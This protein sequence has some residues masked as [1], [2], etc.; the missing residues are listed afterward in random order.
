MT[1]PNKWYNRR[2]GNSRT[3]KITF[4]H[5][6]LIILPS[7]GKLF[8]LIYYVECSRMFDSC[9]LY[10]EREKEPKKERKEVKKRKKRVGKTGKRGTKE[11]R[12]E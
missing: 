5:T 2:K 4:F 7:L 8:C 12:E 10:R 9:G 11:G 1:D 6:G 3:F